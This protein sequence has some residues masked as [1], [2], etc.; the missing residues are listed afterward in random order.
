MYTAKRRALV[1]RLAA[2][3]AA[4]SCIACAAPAG[5]QDKDYGH[6]EDHAALLAQLPKTR[7]SLADGIRQ[8]SKA[9]ETAI[10]FVSGKA[11]AS[12]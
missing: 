2:V 6:E 5:A 12:A 9:A 8:V 11:E 1:G 7:H 3:A 10:A 4:V